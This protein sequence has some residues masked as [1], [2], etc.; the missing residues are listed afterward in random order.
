MFCK[1]N[2]LDFFY[3][4]G[5]YRI[6]AQDYFKPDVRRMIISDTQNKWA[7]SQFGSEF[8]DGSSKLATYIAESNKN[9]NERAIKFIK[10]DPR[11]A[12]FV[13]N[14][15]IM[16]NS[17]KEF[18]NVLRSINN[19]CAAGQEGYDKLAVVIMIT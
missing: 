1:E 9:A 16:D 8:N 17:N 4:S 13:I 3:K 6:Y 19:F 15:F 18:G 11:H 12:I 2:L 7:K 14:F 10:L 5:N